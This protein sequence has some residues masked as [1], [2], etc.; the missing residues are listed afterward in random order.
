MS[1]WL[2]HLTGLTV[3][4]TA[5][6]F[7]T[8]VYQVLKYW[9]F[10]SDRG[11][12]FVRGMPLLGSNYK[13]FFGS[14]PV[15]TAMRR[16][17][18]RFPDEPIIGTYEI[19]GFPNYMIRDPE[20]IK[21]V[22]VKL[23]ENFMNRRTT[24]DAGKDPL[25]GKSLVFARGNEW[26]ELR[27]TVNPSYTASK[28]RGMSGLIIKCANQFVDTLIIA[29]DAKRGGDAMEYEMKDTYSRFA[30][31]TIGSCAFGIE[32][33]S[34]ADRD[35]DFFRM[36]SSVIMATLQFTAKFI[37]YSSIPKLMSFL[38][39]KLLLREN[40][41]YFRELVRLTLKHRQTNK[42]QRNDMIDLLLQARAGTLT[43]DEI[44]TGTTAPP[45]SAA[46]KNIGKQ[47][48][49]LFHS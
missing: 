33:N 30:A 10:F 32:V 43:D 40:E 11:I 44:V 27:R 7:G 1:D 23:S 16:L 45:T 42:V 34:M 17:Y 28:L 48:C 46:N 19:G 4:L 18:E 3:G 6:L 37:G 39:I 26:R 36:G 2:H 20:L 41:H 5:I 35:N 24:V 15:A 25:V 22:A 13:V 47:K 49:I 21:Q 38:G 9:S 8:L 31:D 29:D 12:P 14:V